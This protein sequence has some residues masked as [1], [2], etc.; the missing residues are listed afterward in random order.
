MIYDYTL[1]FCFM[2]HHKSTVNNTKEIVF[3]SIFLKIFLF[4]FQILEIVL[5]YE[6]R[7]LLLKNS[8]YDSLFEKTTISFVK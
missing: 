6:Y 7:I 2:L 1:Y 3:I 5:D 4:S 8:L